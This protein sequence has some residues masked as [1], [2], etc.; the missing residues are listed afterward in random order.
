MG[1]TIFHMPLFIPNDATLCYLM[2]LF[3]IT[4]SQTL[5]VWNSHNDWD[6]LNGEYIF[7]GTWSTGHGSFQ[8][9]K[10]S[11]PSCP[12]HTQYLFAAWYQPDMFH[13]WTFQTS[14]TTDWTEGYP[15]C[16]KDTG[17]V[18]HD[19]SQCQ[20]GWF[21]FDAKTG[22]FTA[23]TI[24]VSNARCPSLSCGAMK[25]SNTRNNKCDQL[26]SKHAIMDNVFQYNSGSGTTYLY[27]NPFTFKWY[28]SDILDVY[29]CN[30]DYTITHPHL[31]SK[32]DGWIDVTIGGQ[33]TWYISNDAIATFK[34][35]ATQHPTENTQ[36]PLPTTAQPTPYPTVIPTSH[37]TQPSSYPTMAPITTMQPTIHPTLQ[38]TILNPTLDFVYTNAPTK[39]SY[40]GIIAP[41]YRYSLGVGVMLG[42]F[43]GLCSCLVLVLFI[44]WKK[45]QKHQMTQGTMM[46]T[47]QTQKEE[48]D[49]TDEMDPDQQD[50]LQEINEQIF[51]VEGDET[52]AHV[53][54]R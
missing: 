9:W 42:S 18:P 4:I 22:T 34:C 43:I 23:L 12:D 11:S 16:S 35:L 29:N 39:S 14:L 5:C 6:H 13:F 38:P 53:S 54:L 44:I 20:N 15:D 17:V 40:S 45:K 21:L 1:A 26:F 33:F 28:C 48:E 10:R 32:Y 30:D 3:T 7:S 36:S 2:S 25:V 37:S 41:S 50:V 8:Y 19:P 49:N 27:F 51:L 24:T 31:T 47:I 46:A 52:T